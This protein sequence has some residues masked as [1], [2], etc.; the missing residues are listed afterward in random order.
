MDVS[1]VS[2]PR[3]VSPPRRITF[4]LFNSAWH[5]HSETRVVKNIQAMVLGFWLNKQETLNTT[6]ERNILGAKCQWSELTKGWNL[7]LTTSQQWTSVDV[8]PSLSETIPCR[9]TSVSGF[10]ES[11]CLSLLTIVTGKLH[12]IVYCSQ[13]LC[14]N[15]STSALCK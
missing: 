2:S 5:M 9:A 11:L 6:R 1:P 8:E 10:S 7:Q 12:F 4:Q 3:D 13:L 14:I 15:V